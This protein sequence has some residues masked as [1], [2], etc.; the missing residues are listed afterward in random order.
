[1]KYKRQSRR[2]RAKERPIEFVV[3][4]EKEFMGWELSIVLKNEDK[5]KNNDLILDIVNA[6]N[7]GRIICKNPRII[8]K[9]RSLNFEIKPVLSFLNSNI[10]KKSLYYYDSLYTSLYVHKLNVRKYEELKLIHRDDFDETLFNKGFEYSYFNNKIPYYYVKYGYGFNKG[11]I[12]LHNLKVKIEKVWATEI[13]LLDREWEKKN[14]F[15][16]NEYTKAFDLGIP[17]KGRQGRY[18]DRYYSKAG[19]YK[20]LRIHSNIHLKNLKQ[21]TNIDDQ[22]LENEFSKNKIRRIPINIK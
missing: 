12:N 18:M 4:D 11:Y 7:Y 16:W 5:Q 9:I 17:Q 20:K 14:D 2:R 22:E 6:N 8:K 3:L 13:G 15:I 10:K 1:L 19:L 21:L